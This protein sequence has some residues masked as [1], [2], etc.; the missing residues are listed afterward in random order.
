IHS[1]DHDPSN[2]NFGEEAVTQLQVDAERV[3]KTLLVFLDVGNLAVAVVPVARQLNLKLI[4]TTLGAKKAKMCDSKEAE[5]ATGYIVGGISPLGQKKQLPTV[6]DESANNWD[7]IYISA[8]RRG[9]EIELKAED[10]CTLTMGR[11]ADIS[12]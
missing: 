12:R 1:Y 6:V 11:F 7:T 3:F 2:E 10:L 5:R 8:G 4:A 9:L